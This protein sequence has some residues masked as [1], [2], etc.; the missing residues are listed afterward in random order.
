[1]AHFAQL[2]E[3]NVVMQVI[4]VHNNELMDNGVESEAKGVAFCQSLFGVYTNWKQTS[5]NGNIRK[6]YAGINFIYCVDI[7]AFVPPQPYPSWTLDTNA[8][9]QPPVT[10]PLDDKRYFWDE[11]TTSWIEQIQPE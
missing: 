8:Q 6:N 10:M 1:M 4:V 11:A 2:D 3:N 5:Y 7:D 9:W